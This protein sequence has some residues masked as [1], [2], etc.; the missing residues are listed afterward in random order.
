MERIGLSGA[1][2]CFGKLTDLFTYVKPNSL[3]FDMI[4]MV[5]LIGVREFRRMKNKFPIFDRRLTAIK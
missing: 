4:Q 3:H 5:V 2:I 1:I